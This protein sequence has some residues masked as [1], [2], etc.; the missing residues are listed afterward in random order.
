VGYGSNDLLPATADLRA[1]GAIS[2]ILYTKGNGNLS[3]DREGSGVYLIKP[4]GQYD[5]IDLFF[6]G[7]ES[8]FIEATK[9]AVSRALEN[10][11][12]KESEG[13]ETDFESPMNSIGSLIEN[14]F[15]DYSE[16]NKLSGL[17]RTVAGM[18]LAS[19]VRT[20]KHLIG[21]QRLSLEIAGK[22]QTVGGQ[23]DVAT[24]TLK[25]GFAWIRQKDYTDFV[26]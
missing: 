8:G 23:I 17:R 2:Q 1:F 26:D 5:A 19:L 16:S 11:T 4:S 14:S 21:I 24:I 15:F 13:S 9:T 7:Y 18:P 3:A 25:D 22:L 10:A 6:R 20:V 12:V